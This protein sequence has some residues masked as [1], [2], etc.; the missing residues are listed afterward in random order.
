MG[1]MYQKGQG[2]AAD[3]DAALKWYR[4]A[5]ELGNGAAMSNIGVLYQEGLGVKADQAEAA[6]W[7]AKATGAGGETN[8]GLQGVP[9]SADR[10]ARPADATGP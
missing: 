2:M 6:K 8:N 9:P 5:A 1:V 7:F 4:H 3:Y 10:G